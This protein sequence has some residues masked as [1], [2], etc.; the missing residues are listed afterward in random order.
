MTPTLPAEQLRE[1]ETAW[2]AK[3]LGDSIAN[4]GYPVGMGIP[5]SDEALS[6]AAN[7]LFDRFEKLTAA[8]AQDKP[9]EG[10]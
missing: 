10:E 4:L 2:I 7:M 3:C 9:Q 6:R 1:I 5:P 8:I